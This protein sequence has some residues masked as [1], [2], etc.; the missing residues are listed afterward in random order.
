M[1]E[2]KEN[3]KQTKS[4]ARDERL[5]KALRDNLKRRKVQVKQRNNVDDAQAP[6]P[7]KDKIK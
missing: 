1:V 5:Q 7:R 3:T 6:L 4:S 2:Q